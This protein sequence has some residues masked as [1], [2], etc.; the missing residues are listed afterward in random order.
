T[1]NINMSIRALVTP[2]INQSDEQI[3]DA[4][5]RFTSWPSLV[6]GTGITNIFGDDY[7]YIVRMG[8]VQFLNSPFSVY[9]P[10]T[11]TSAHRAYD[12]D[13]GPVTGIPS[14]TGSNSSGVNI[15]G[16]GSGFC[17]YTVEFGLDNGNLG[18]IRSIGSAITLASGPTLP[19][20]Q[21][22]FSNR[23][24]GTGALDSPIPKDATREISFDLGI[25]W[26]R[27]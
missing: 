21:V 6:D 17:N 1:T 4:S 25:T 26:D 19:I 24:E 7:D 5:Y 9:R 10:S 3:L 22:E 11:V 27:H 16:Q 23:G 12:D 18:G 20:I 2:E 13:I 14:G 8:N 15:T